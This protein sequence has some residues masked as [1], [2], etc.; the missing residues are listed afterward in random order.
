MILYMMNVYHLGFAKANYILFL[1]SAATNFTPIIGA[2]LADSYMGR[3]LTIS[4]GCIVSLLVTTISSHSTFGSGN[5]SFLNSVESHSQAVSYHK[6]VYFTLS[7][8]FQYWLKFC[9]NSY[10]YQI[11]RKFTDQYCVCHFLSYRK[12]KKILLI[13]HLTITPL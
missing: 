4:L 6:N 7:L 1:W 2:F 9:C 10:G 13:A 12:R 11:K 8:P 3:C 5:F